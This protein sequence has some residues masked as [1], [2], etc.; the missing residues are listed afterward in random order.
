MGKEFEKEWIH[1]ICLLYIWNY[2][3][4]ANQLYSNIKKLNKKNQDR[5]SQTD[6]SQLQPTADSFYFLIVFHFNYIYF[7]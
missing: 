6:T 4:I 3:N 7:N 2:D 1:E 5:V